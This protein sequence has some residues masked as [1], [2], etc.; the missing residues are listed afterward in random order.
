MQQVYFFRYI[1]NS[2][3]FFLPEL[4]H[5]RTLTY[6]H[7]QVSVGQNLMETLKPAVVQFL[8]FLHEHFNLYI[9]SRFNTILCCQSRRCCVNIW[10]TQ[11]DK[12]ENLHMFNGNGPY[13][14]PV[15]GLTCQYRTVATKAWHTHSHK[16]FAMRRGAGQNLGV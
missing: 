16:V 6:S 14:Q 2:G 11:E 4:F 13:V 9:N 5:I 1:D 10:G 8:I 15:E 12:E 7:P 3:M